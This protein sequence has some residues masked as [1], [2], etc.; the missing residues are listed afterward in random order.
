M[1]AGRSH[2]I[3]LIVFKMT[4][5]MKNPLEKNLLKTVTDAHILM[6]G[7]GGIGCE[8]LKN[9]VMTGFRKI[10]II[11]LDTID[12]SNLN[13]QFLFHKCHVGK[14]KALVA[15]ESALKMCPQAQIVALHDTIFNQDYNIQYFKKFDIVLNALDNVAARKHVNRMCLAADIPL[16]ESGSSGYLGQT[17]LIK[18][19]VS[20]CYECQPT[21]RQKTFP[22]CTIR[23]T[24]SQLIHCVVWAKYLFNQLFG[25]EDA[26]KDVAPDQEDEENK[27]NGD[28]TQPIKRVNT[29]E[30]AKENN[31]DGEAVFNKLFNK[32]VQYLLS[33]KNLWKTRRP[34]TPMKWRDSVDKEMNVDGIDVQKLMTTE[35]NMALFYQSI[36]HL[37]NKL[38]P[39]NEVLYWDKDDKH[40]MNFTS[41][42]ANIRAEIF[43]IEGKSQFNLK[44]MAGNIIPAIATTNAMVAGLILYQ[45]F[46]ALQ[47]KIAES[48]NTIVDKLP[49]NTSKRL[50]GPQCLDPPR[51]G[52]MICA[53]KPQVTIAVN[54][55]ELT[56]KDFRD[57]VLCKGLGLQQPDVTT[58]GKIVLSSDED[59]HTEEELLR[60]LSDMNWKSG[61]DMDVEDF[62][63]DY[64][65]FVVLVATEKPFEEGQFFKKVSEGETKLSGNLTENGNGNHDDVVSLNG[66]NGK[67]KEDAS[68]N[69]KRKISLVDEA[70]VDSKKPKIA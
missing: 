22:G 1:K 36:D 37:K 54:F 55:D 58:K 9:L 21:P 14:P 12:V 51:A 33:M 61:I 17:Q 10:E 60:K 5:Q 28:S 50:I 15:K 68:L 4:N 53:D 6:V 11:D 39:E 34:P 42:A 16:V 70:P 23:N 26:D 7:S 69:Q 35:E 24:P 56:L 40:A 63:T 2:K 62:V 8:L 65:V 38:S 46:D 67:E 25:E 29:R 13:R 32:D 30:W 3:L 19:N 47:G 49:R 59:D 52:C 31:F 41:A 45:T 64:K 48:K 57:K 43:G 18:K 66:Q 20:Q 44:A 27:S